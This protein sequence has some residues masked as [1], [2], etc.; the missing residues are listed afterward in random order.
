HWTAP[1]KFHEDWQLVQA[2]DKQRGG[3]GAVP[4]FSFHRYGSDFGFAEA[5][6][7]FDEMTEAP[8]PS[9]TKYECKTREATE[10][11]VLLCRVDGN[12]G[13]LGYGRIEVEKISLTKPDDPAIKVLN[14]RN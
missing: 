4:C 11:L 5:T 12:S 1:P 9:E 2:I 10:G 14:S 7:S 13:N 8:K 3:F 6:G